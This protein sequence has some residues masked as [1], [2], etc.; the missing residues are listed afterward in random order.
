[1]S[2]SRMNPAISASEIV[3]GIYLEHFHIAVLQGRGSPPQGPGDGHS[4]RPFSPTHML[5][6]PIPHPTLSR[7]RGD[8]PAVT[9]RNMQ[10]GYWMGLKLSIQN[11]PQELHIQ[12]LLETIGQTIVGAS[13]SPTRLSSALAGQ[14]RHGPHAESAAGSQHYRTT[15]AHSSPTPA[16]LG[17]IAPSSSSTPRPL[18]V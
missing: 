5:S 18:R 10:A 9:G 11:L 3:S 15:H 14:T 4:L 17:A 16:P 8:M 13:G 2:R 6:S 1:M 12:V 7:G